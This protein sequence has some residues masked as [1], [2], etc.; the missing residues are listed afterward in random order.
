MIWLITDLRNGVDEVGVSR[1][2]VASHDPR[3][4]LGADDEILEP[5]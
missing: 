3:L 4:P 1:M 5:F 2:V